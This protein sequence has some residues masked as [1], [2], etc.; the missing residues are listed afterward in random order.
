MH[1]LDCGHDFTMVL[2]GLNQK[3]IHLPINRRM[4]LQQQVEL[5]IHVFK[6]DFQTMFLLICHVFTP[7]AIEP[8]ICFFRQLHDKQGVMHLAFMVACLSQQLM[9]RI[10]DFLTFEGLGKHLVG[11]DF[12][13]VL[14][15]FE[16]TASVA[17]A[18]DC[19]HLHIGEFL[20]QIQNGRDALFIRHEDIGNNKVRW[21]PLE[22]LYAL[23]AIG[24]FRYLM[25]GLFQHL[26]QHLPEE[27]LVINNQNA[28]HSIIPPI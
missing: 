24:G 1:G 27:L 21:L 6:D 20:F 5:T 2:Q 17:A 12:A 8:A 14:Q 15:V 10:E 23:R 16:T 7:L 26:P 4:T 3:A 18:G 13:R 22:G 28:R 9:N 19:N 11:T 25:A